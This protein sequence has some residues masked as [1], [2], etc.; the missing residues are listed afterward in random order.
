MGLNHTVLLDW[1]NM[2][3][4]L[5]VPA[6][7]HAPAQIKREALR[8]LGILVDDDDYL[9]SLEQQPRISVIDFF[10]SL[11]I[12]QAEGLEQ[13][14]AEPHFHGLARFANIATP[15]EYISRARRVL[16]TTS[17]GRPPLWQ[18]PAHLTEQAANSERI[19]RKGFSQGV[20]NKE[21]DTPA[22]I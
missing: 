3:N 6:Y 19:W 1:R 22:R 13:A 17:Y 21:L 16:T 4:E 8:I 7:I 11:R 5:A 2:F 18:L 10:L 20:E 14:Y 12:W 9:S 15:G